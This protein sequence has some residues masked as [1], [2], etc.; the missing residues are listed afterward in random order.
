MTIEGKVTHV[1]DVQSGESKRGPWRKLEFVVEIPG[2]YP[3][4][5]CCTVWNDSIDEADL[6]V[7]DQVHV[8]IDI[9]SREYNGRW[10]TDVTAWKIQK[11]GQSTYSSA[12]NSTISSNPNIGGDLPF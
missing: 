3:K 8:N 12:K 4:P 10:Y 11:Q 5:V 1:M 6:H 2:D 7:G 9:K